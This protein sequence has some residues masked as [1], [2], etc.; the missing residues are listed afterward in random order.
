MTTNDTSDGGQTAD[1]LA[2]LQQRRVDETTAAAQQ[3]AADTSVYWGAVRHLAG[4][5]TEAPPVDALDAAL[6]RLGTVPGALRADAD[7]LARLLRLRNAGDIS[8]AREGVDAARVA[9]DADLQ[10]ASDLRAQADRVEREAHA[11]LGAAERALARTEKAAADA[12]RLT[13]ALRARGCPLNPTDEPAPAP[14]R[15]DLHRARTLIDCFVDGRARRAG[16][17]FVTHVSPRDG[18]LELVGAQGEPAAPRWNG[19]DPVPLKRGDDSGI[20]SRDWGGVLGVDGFRARQEA[21]AAQAATA[22]GA[23]K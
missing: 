18:V 14:K 8:E 2:A 10:Q 5:G 19:G 23:P 9:L 4:D 1:I 22:E 15:R 6:R 13:E 11:K 3:H 21:L 16:E 20:D 12:T 7:A 17:E